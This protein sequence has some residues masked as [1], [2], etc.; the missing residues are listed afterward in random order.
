MDVWKELMGRK[1]GKNR[2]MD[3]WFERELRRRLTE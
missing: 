3:A 2:W 1:G